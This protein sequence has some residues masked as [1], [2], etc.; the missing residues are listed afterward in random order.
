MASCNFLLFLYELAK[1]YS[2]GIS[3]YLSY[4][5]LM[6]AVRAGICY[7]LADNGLFFIMIEEF[8]ILLVLWS[9]ATL[10]KA[11]QGFERFQ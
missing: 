10:L 3:N 5:N 7:Y 1:A 2:I 6:D 11:F 4:W 9:F 8:I